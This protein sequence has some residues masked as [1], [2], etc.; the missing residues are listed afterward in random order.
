LTDTI[1]TSCVADFR[2]NVLLVQGDPQ[3]LDKSRVETA[4][5][6][7]M[8]ILFW[9]P[10][11]L[12]TAP[13]DPSALSICRRDASGNIIA[14]L[15]RVGTFQVL[16]MQAG[17]TTKSVSSKQAKEV[18]P[19]EQQ[20]FLETAVY[21]TGENSRRVYACKRCRAREAGRKKKKEESRKKRHSGSESSSSNQH[22]NPIPS[23]GQPTPDY[24]TGE[25]PE[26]YDPGRK[27]QVV[28]EP[29]WEP[30]RKDWRHDFVSFNT[31][32]EVAIKDGSIESLPFRMICYAKCHGEKLGF[33]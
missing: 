24:V 32:P 15:G 5:R 8:D 14:H 18:L 20:V 30:M 33:R 31:A 11:T 6:S 3:Y 2:R 13:S 26:Q 19:R 12:E 25:N 29:A 21:T 1:G 22:A 4:I 17:T 16:R 10:P 7:S 9:I 23:K 28:E 27:D